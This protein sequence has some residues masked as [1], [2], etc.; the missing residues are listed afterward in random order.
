MQAF[1]KPKLL[2]LSKEVQPK[3]LVAE[4]AE[5]MLTS[6]AGIELVDKYDAYQVLMSYWIETMQDDVYALC[7]E[8]YLDAREIEYEYSESKSKNND[9]P[10]DKKI[11]GWDGKIIPKSIIEAE[12][13]AKD[14]KTIDKLVEQLTVAENSLNDLVEEHS[15]E[16]GYFSDFVDGDKVDKKEIIAKYKELKKATAND[17]EFEVFESY[18]SFVEDVSKFSK[19]IKELEKDLDDKLKAKYATF[20]EQEIKHLVIDKKWFA[21][22]YNGVDELYTAISHRIANRVVELAERYETTLS[23]CEK[24]VETYE[25]KVKAHLAKMG[26]KL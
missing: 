8:G 13:F 7:H 17:E 2:N 12:Y 24:K 22:I 25:S 5:K 6:F 23:E 3:K 18:N 14:R 4:L 19:A 11:K 26:Y 10:K 16:D 21:S 1:A 20:T 9:K 15:G